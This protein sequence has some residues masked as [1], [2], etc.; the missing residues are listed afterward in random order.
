M[1]QEKKSDAN[2]DLSL[3]RQCPHYNGCSKNFCP[4]DE[5]LSDRV[6]KNSEKCR[7]MREPKTKKISGRTFISGGSVMP[8]A[9]LNFVPEGN[10]KCLNRASQERRINLTAKERESV[11]E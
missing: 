10:L 4:L 1:A 2:L 7:Y 5:N 3:L 8:D 11:C 6:G 9:P